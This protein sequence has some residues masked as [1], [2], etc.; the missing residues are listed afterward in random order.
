MS[1]KKDYED[2]T[3]RL[4]A[5]EGK[6]RLVGVDNWE[7]PFPSDFLIGDY[8]S[9]EDATKAGKAARERYDENIELLIYNDEG[10][11]IKEIKE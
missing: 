3:T 10:D 2:A 6:F 4:T 11:F 1:F 5:P 8:G 7:A 9:L